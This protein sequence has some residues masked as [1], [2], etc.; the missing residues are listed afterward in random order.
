MEQP[1]VRKSPEEIAAGLRQQA[2]AIN[3]R[4]SWL[5]TLA[6]FIALAG[7]ALSLVDLVIRFF[8]LNAGSFFR[9][10]YFATH[11]VSVFLV[12]GAY[13]YARQTVLGIAFFVSILA[14]FFDI[15]A[16]GWESA[17]VNQ[18]TLGAPISTLDNDICTGEVSLFYIN[19]IYA[20]L[21]TLLAVV[22]SVVCYFWLA[23]MSEVRKKL[24]EA[25]LAEKIGPLPPTNVSLVTKTAFAQRAYIIGQQEEHKI[26]YAAQQLNAYFLGSLTLNYLHL[27]FG[28]LGALYLLAL[29]ITEM[30]YNDNAWSYRLGFLMQ[31]GFSFAASLVT[32]G[33]VSRYWP[34]VILATAL[35]GLVGALTATYLE[36]LRQIRCPL[37]NNDYESQICAAGGQ[38][39][40]LPISAPIISTFLIVSAVLSGLSLWKGRPIPPKAS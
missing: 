36:I 32:W 10:G 7:I 26:R 15:Y 29:T 18:C 35:V 1:A 4:S 31:S 40:I 23:R 3:E 5:R 16:A 25:R 11:C 13:Y 34:V 19:L 39:L 12:V 8:Y 21:F 6:F 33:P 9:D 24:T 37:F 30:I 14:F 22:Q 17:R 28:M 2:I 27:T 20:W 38:G